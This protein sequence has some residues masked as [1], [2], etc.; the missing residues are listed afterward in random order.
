MAVRVLSLVWDHYPSGG[1]ELLALLALADWSDDTGRC[2]PSI[3]SI[4]RKTRLSQKQARRMVHAIIG[5][6]YLT[7]IDNVQGG[8]TSRRYQIN[9]KRL[10][11]PPGDGSAP[12]NVPD[13]S[14]GREAT[15]PTNGSR[16][17]SEPSL[18]VKDVAQALPC[19]ADKIVDAYHRKMPTNPKCKVL[20]A[21]RRGAI[22]TRWNEAAK[23]SSKPFGYATV[24]DG[25]VAWESFFEICAG[26]KFLTGQVKP[27]P[28]KP[29]FMA[30]IDFLFSPKGFAGCI[31]NKYHREAA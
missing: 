22:K 19:P 24:N 26:S 30:D 1:S 16:T 18:P 31:E 23:L 28:G 8:A 9:L 13:P 12:T 4:A 29:P 27:L 15:P 11:T 21:S 2:W 5:A 6:G 7:V 10:S 20:N 3:A 14:L 25:L 17:V